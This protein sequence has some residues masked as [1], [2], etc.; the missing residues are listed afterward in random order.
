[1]SNENNLILGNTEILQVCIKCPSSAELS[2]IDHRNTFLYI[3][4]R[5]NPELYDKLRVGQEPKVFTIPTNL[6]HLYVIPSCLLNLEH[7]IDELKY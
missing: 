7:P 1:M 2:V 6:P 4:C 5:Q 3:V